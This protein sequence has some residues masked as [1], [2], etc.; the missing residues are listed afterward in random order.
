MMAALT[1]FSEIWGTKF[2]KKWSFFKKPRISGLLG[3]YRNARPQRPRCI[4]GR[5]AA[6]SDSSAARRRDASCRDPNWV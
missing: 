4:T 6:P 5:V 1:Y 3:G 2:S